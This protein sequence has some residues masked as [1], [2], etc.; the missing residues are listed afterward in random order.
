MVRRGAVALSLRN[1]GVAVLSNAHLYDAL[2]IL[3]SIF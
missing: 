1:S 2:I 3:V